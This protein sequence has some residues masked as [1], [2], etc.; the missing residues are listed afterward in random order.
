MAEPCFQ[1]EVRGG[2]E[3][4]RLHLAPFAAPST[5][6]KVYSFKRRARSR[7]SPQPSPRK[8]GERGHGVSLS[9]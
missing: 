7:P 8:D 6:A 9:P 1:H 4:Q 2:H 5:L 3:P